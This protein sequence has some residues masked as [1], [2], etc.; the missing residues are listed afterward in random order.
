MGQDDENDTSQQKV[1]LVFV[2][3]EFISDDANTYE[4]HT[5]LGVFVVT[6]TEE[7]ALTDEPD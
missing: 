7:L 5:Y 6:T 4:S 3:S 1:F 2:A